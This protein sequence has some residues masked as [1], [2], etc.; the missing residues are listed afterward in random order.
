MNRR[1]R[2]R[3]YGGVRGRGLTPSYSIADLLGIRFIPSLH[4]HRLI[5]VKEEKQSN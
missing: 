2:N 5:F 1:I 4:I 3:M